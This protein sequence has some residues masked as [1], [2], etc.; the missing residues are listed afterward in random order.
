MAA[1]LRRYRTFGVCGSTLKDVAEASGVPLGNLYYYFKTRDELLL[2]VLDEC[3]RQLRALLDDLAPRAPRDWLAGYFRWLLDHA[4]DA[5]QFGCPF[6]TLAIELRAL[7][8]PAAPRAAE[9]VRHYLGAVAAQAGACGLPDAAAQDLFL[10]VQGA[11][12]VSRVLGDEALFRQSVTR[13]QD[14]TLSARPG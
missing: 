9:I 5:A 13:L 6:G 4:G 7:D 8:D 11:Y 3:E 10:S 1:A 12:T 14:R 2:A